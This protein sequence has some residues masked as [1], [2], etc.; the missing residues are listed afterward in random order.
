MTDMITLIG[1]LVPPEAFDRYVA[2]RTQADDLG[3]RI[4]AAGTLSEK[5]ALKR[6]QARLRN[7]A[8]AAINA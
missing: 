2:L 5:L 4:C 3:A 7:Q 6:E 1:K 8:R